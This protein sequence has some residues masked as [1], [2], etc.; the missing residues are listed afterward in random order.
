MNAIKRMI[1]G[2]E[3]CIDL[4]ENEREMIYIHL[5]N[6]YI[7]DSLSERAKSLGENVSREKLIDV[8]YLYSSSGSDINLELVN[9]IVSR[10]CKGGH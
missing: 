9:G 4:T 7:M 2:K 6:E 8:L 10:I 1:D 3:V 5:R